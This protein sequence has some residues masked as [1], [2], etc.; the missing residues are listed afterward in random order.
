MVGHPHEQASRPTS[1]LITSSVG[2]IGSATGR[3]LHSKGATIAALYAPF[4]SSK[5][6][7]LL[8][9][10]YGSHAPSIQIYECDVTSESAVQS[11]FSQI[12]SSIGSNDQKHFP[13]IL[14][15][16]AGYVNLCPMEDTPAEDL[17]LIHI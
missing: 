1:R 3:L 9:S 4:E 2:G 16:C 8:D 13:S 17:S 11:T 6:E 15:N 7:Q 12:S 10:G 14:A 5:R